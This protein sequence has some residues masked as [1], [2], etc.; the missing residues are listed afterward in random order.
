MIVSPRSTTDSDQEARLKRELK[1]KK[2]NLHL[3]E[4]MSSKASGNEAPVEE[5]SG[6]YFSS[7]T[8]LIV[9]N[10]QIYIDR[11]HIR[12][13]DATSNPKVCLFFHSFT[14]FFVLDL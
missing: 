13:E 1:I 11:V 4:L 6:G 8:S 12:Y 7:Y 2:R 5:N 9:N 14:F 3:A 10:L